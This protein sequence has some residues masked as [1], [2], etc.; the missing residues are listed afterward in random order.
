ME[1]HLSLNASGRKC[2][3]MAVASLKVCDNVGGMS[4]PSTSKVLDYL[5]SSCNNENKVQEVPEYNGNQFRSEGKVKKR[6]RSVERDFRK[7]LKFE[8]PPEGTLVRG[9]LVKRAGPYLLG[10]T[11]GTSPVQSIVQCL[12][13]REG[14]DSFYT[15]KILTLRGKEDGILGGR[16]GCT[17]DASE[18]DIEEETQDD[19][20]GKML[21]HTEH[22][23]LSLLKDQDGVIHHHDFFKDYA[24]EERD[25]VSAYGSVQRVYAGKANVR[26]CLVLDCLWAHDFCPSR[27]PAPL[28]NLQH[29]VIRERKL[30]QREALIIF[31]H[32]VKVIQDLHA[33]NIVHRD[34]KLGNIV[35]NRRN[36]T[37]TLTN[38]CLGKQLGSETDLLVDQK[39]SPAYIS[40][41]VLHGKPYLGK[42]SDMWALGVVLYTMLYG[43]FPFYDSSPSQLFAKI[44]TATYTTPKDGR[45]T[46]DAAA[47]IANL[48]V[49]DPIQ[50]YTASQVL[51]SLTSIISPLGSLLRIHQ[52][53][54][55]SQKLQVVPD[56]DDISEEQDGQ[57]RIKE[58]D[59]EFK[60]V[61]ST[62]VRNFKRRHESEKTVSWAEFT[63]G[64]SNV[65]V[66]RNALPSS[67]TDC[68]TLAMLNSV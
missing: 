10:P 19:R 24:L 15:L 25:E 50:R 46:Y 61:T 55:S 18:L 17:D 5:K 23:I 30:P 11:L 45:V 8:I 47:L 3:D 57:I 37:V 28:I 68:L 66:Q 12:A 7:R 63:N 39:G 59:E 53:L 56:I 32:T 20:Q 21:L 60:N 64:R 41:E 2:N 13:R 6:P 65:Q 14:T 52:S 34:L 29:H 51:E 31:Y 58:F 42:P 9:G 36:L 26:L 38:F 49:L 33:K 67:E 62:S 4:S 40:P 16:V 35:V 22:S 44:K 43:Q 54:P 1:L 27:P 48:L